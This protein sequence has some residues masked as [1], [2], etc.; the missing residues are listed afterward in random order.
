MTYGWTGNLLRVNLTTGQISTE[1]SSKYRD[2]LGGTGIGDRIMYD[3]VPVGTK[4]FDEANKIIYAVGPNTGTSSPCSGR[5]TITSLSTFTKGNMVVNAHM[6][7]EFAVQLKYAGYDALVVEGQ[8][9][10]PVYIKIENDNVSIEDASDIWGKTTRE[11][12]AAICGKEGQGFCVASIGLAGEN[13]VNLSCM[14]NAGNHCG[15]AG[16][17]AV[18][19][20]KKLKAVAVYGKGSVK[21]ADPK[22][23]LELNRYVMSDLMGSNNNHVV[24]ST[25]RPWAEFS[26]PASRWTGRP[27]LTWGAAEGGPVDT[28]DAP[29]GEPTKIGYRCQKAYKDFGPVSE[30]YTVK[31]TGCTSCPIRCSATVYL[32]ELEKEGYVAAVSNTCM[33]N[34]M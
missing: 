8:S 7:G 17:G 21:V 16:T 1:D 11:T 18:M 14:I 22:K 27:G 12:S 29:P 25:E 3:E 24:P 2:Y 15:G 33:P 32:P 13:L 30:K 4:P 6:G 23:I 31:M 9:S 28:G 19:G 10:T 20:S 26:D 5:T 34:F